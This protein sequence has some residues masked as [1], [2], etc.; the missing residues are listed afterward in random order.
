FPFSIGTM[1]AIIRLRERIHSM[2]INF[3]IGIA[4]PLAGFVMAILV[5]FYGFINL[6][7]AEYIYQIHPEY[8]KFGPDYENFVYG[9]QEGIIDVVIG[10]N[11]LFQFF[12]SFIADTDRMPNPHEI[13]H[14]PYL[15]AGFLALVF[16][17]LNLI[18]VGQLDGGHVL[19]GLVGYQRHK[20]IAS[21]IFVGFMFYAGLGMVYPQQPLDDLIFY[22]PAYIIFLTFCFKG[23]KLPIRD[24]V[25]YALLV[26]A[27]QF[28]WA[29]ISPGI[30][31]YSGWLLF[32]LIIG[33][34]AGVHHPQATI[35]EPLDTNRQILGWLAL[36]IFVICFSPNP[37]EMQ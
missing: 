14:Y 7:P 35:E 3:D 37:I 10:K 11:I 20:I 33:R 21:V 27:G 15:F 2:K 32:G 1:G 34:M 23:L 8:E 9:H 17:S 18:P 16:T 24:T 31:G 6:P 25:M 28:I 30:T 12:E 19:Y 26:F 13:M 29:W 36:L 5:L 4:G 22:V